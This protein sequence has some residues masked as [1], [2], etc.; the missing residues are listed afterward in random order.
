MVGGT[1][2]KEQV[3]L[4]VAAARDEA[5]VQREQRERRGVGLARTLAQDRELAVGDRGEG[6]DGEM[7][8]TRRHEGERDTA[9]WRHPR[10]VAGGAAGRPVAPARSPVPAAHPPGRIGMDRSEGPY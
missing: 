5:A 3:A 1:R 2:V 8:R 9:D 7:A 10:N 6:S 4:V